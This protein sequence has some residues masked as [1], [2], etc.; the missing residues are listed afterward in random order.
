MTESSRPL[1]SV[2]G[3]T[4]RYGSADAVALDDVSFEVDRGAMVAIVGESGSGK[5]TTALSII[6]LLG[7][8]A[9]VE[10]GSIRY[11]G[12]ELTE[13]SDRALRRLRG[14]KI[15]FV[16]QDPT[17]S[18]DPT[19]RIGGQ[20]SEVLEIHGHASRKDAPTRAV[21]ILGAVGL[22][23]P[24]R[25]ARQ[26]PHELSGGMRQ[27][28]LIGMA[29]A[30]EPQ[31]II[32]DEPTSALD[33]TVQRQVLDRLD[34]LRRDS[35]TAVLLVTHDLA[36]AA[37]RADHLIVMSGGRVVEHGSTS[38]VLANPRH[39]Y[40]R[41]LLSTVPT[42]RAAFAKKTVGSRTAATPVVVARNLVKEFEAVDTTGKRTR[43]TAVNDVGFSI[44]R[45]RTFALVG[46]SGSGKSTTA[47][48]IMNLDKPTSGTV[49][50]DGT[51]TSTLGSGELRLLRKR[52]QLIQQNPYSSL[53][54]RWSV[55]KIIEEPLRAFGVGSRTERAA[56][57]R[58]LLDQVGLPTSFASRRASELSGGQRQ[59]VAIARALA[60]EPEL[61]VCDEPISA[62]DV[63]VQA[64]ILDLLADL[65]RELSVSY[66]FISHDLSVVRLIA[67]D[68]A[69]MKEGRIVEH[70]L[71]TN[72]FD[73]PT[74]E[75]TAALIDA[76]PGRRASVGTEHG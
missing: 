24:E 9:S 47:R 46:E 56:R 22:S 44:E 13:L 19:Q 51:D 64:Q 54:P 31:L 42:E 2:R 1:L 72:V 26:Y 60:V 65:Q 14:N 32:A 37:D 30:C 25:R 55:A 50:F 5:S 27:R 7:A 40:T 75:Y 29:W 66:L 48:M 67:D 6:G 49:T 20:I 52:F 43:I 18:L 10:A 73:S 21:E 17:V 59:R 45:G 58:K 33:V 41:Q 23:E 11:D 61:I 8:T 34:T 38:E 28:V 36:V 15:G 16:P 74:H 76:I 39:E 62:L 63:S 53:S 3:L 12:T 4:V 71:V 35:G 70:G 68:V 57:S 69:V